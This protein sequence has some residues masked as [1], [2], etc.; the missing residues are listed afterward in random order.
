MPT[1]P[2]EELISD[3]DEILRRAE[4]GEEFT[5][6]VSGQ[7]VAKLGPARKQWVDGSVL[8]ELAKLPVDPGYRRDIEDFDIELRDPWADR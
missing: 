6:T 7:A 4:D 2:L 3:I 8:E 1:I 5:I